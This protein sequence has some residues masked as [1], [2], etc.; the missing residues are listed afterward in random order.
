MDKVLETA[1]IWLPIL[2]VVLSSIITGLSKMPEASGV[3]NVLKMILQLFSV[4][5]PKDAPGTLKM[6]LKVMKHPGKKEDRTTPPGPPAAVMILLLA[7]GVLL[8]TNGCSWL[9]SVA[10]SGAG[11][12][13][14]NCAVEAVAGK[15]AELVAT[16]RAIVTGGAVNW[17][18]QLEALKSIGE[19]ALACALHNVADDLT[20]E[21]LPAATDPPETKKM[22]ATAGGGAQKAKLFLKEKGWNTESK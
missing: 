9:G 1:K 16:V 22:K 18:E 21:S 2:V 4:L 3:V 6:P 7:S 19:D 13:V 10:G 12:S 11:Q 8:S 17:K 20:R 15:A 5:T 14:I